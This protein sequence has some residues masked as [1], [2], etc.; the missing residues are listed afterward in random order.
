MPVLL[1]KTCIKRTLKKR[2]LPPEKEIQ[3]CS[4]QLDTFDPYWNERQ[5]KKVFFCYH[6]SLFA[7]STVTRAYK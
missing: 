4:G 2:F 5:G 1:S 7:E 3:I 6:Y